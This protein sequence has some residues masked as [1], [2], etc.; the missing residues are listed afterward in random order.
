MS[1]TE[2]LSV[3][4][5][6]QTA[7][8]LTW[9][10]PGDDGNTGTAKTYDLRYSTSKINNENKW[11]SA[12]QAIGESIPQ[13]VGSDEAYTAVGLTPETTYYFA[14]KTTDQAGNISELSNI[15]EGNTKRHIS[16]AEAFNRHGYKWEHIVSV[17]K[18]EWEWYGV[19]TSLK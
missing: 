19:G 3:S 14:F 9:I 13:I 5:T 17:N 15:L 10:S 4:A 18:K 8:D 1:K 7:I 16:S 2:D 12:I 6:T 11:E